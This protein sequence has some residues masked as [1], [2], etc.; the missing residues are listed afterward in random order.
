MKNIIK[1]VMV[2]GLLNISLFANN[3]FEVTNIGYKY[4]SKKNNVLVCNE[5]DNIVKS[6]AK[7]S[8]GATPIT[9]YSNLPYR[10]N[11]EGTTRTIKVN[12]EYVVTDNNFNELYR[13]DSNYE[14][15]K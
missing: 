4:C 1:T 6:N 9:N 8:I 7:S 3:G 15:K 2:I 13:L 5:V 14:I 12:N 10:P 11:R